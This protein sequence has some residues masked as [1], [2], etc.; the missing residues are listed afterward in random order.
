MALGGWRRRWYLGTNADRATF[1]TLHTA[2]LMARALREGLSEA[3]ADQTAKH[4]RA[5]ISAPAVA[6]T[7]TTTLLAWDGSASHHAASAV[8]SARTGIERGTTIVIEH[9]DMPCEDPNCQIRGAV[10]APLVVAEGVVGTLQVYA[11]QVSAILVRATT[12]VAQWVSAQLELAER[13]ASRGRLM[14][15]EVKAL[16][17]QISPHFIYNSL[18]AIA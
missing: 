3:G 11:P 18:T 5:L 14:A 2:S 4:V 13:D 8:P 16:R 6:I 12:E 10:V 9:R 17:A 7:N 15:A 1:R